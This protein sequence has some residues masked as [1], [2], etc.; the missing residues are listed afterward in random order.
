MIENSKLDLTYILVHDQIVRH[1]VRVLIKNNILNKIEL[2]Q[3][4]N[5][6]LQ[7]I[8]PFSIQFYSNA[9]KITHFYSSI[10][11]QTFL[12]SSFYHLKYSLSLTFQ[13]L[14]LYIL[15]LLLVLFWMLQKN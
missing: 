9:I 14:S 10:F 2:K 12:K 4:I 3:I 13:M 7:M 6:H 8:L 1:H 5:K 11:H 15:L